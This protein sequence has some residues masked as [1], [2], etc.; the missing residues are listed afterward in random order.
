MHTEDAK[1]RRWT[2]DDP[3]NQPVPDYANSFE[4]AIRSDM[5]TSAYIFQKNQLI[6]DLSVTQMYFHI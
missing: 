6:R 2:D 5:F 4:V 3:C 1:R